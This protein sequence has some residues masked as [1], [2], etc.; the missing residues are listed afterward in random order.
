[1]CWV[2]FL[3]ALQ[4]FAVEYGVYTLFTRPGALPYGMVLVW[5][6]YWIWIPMIFPLVVFVPLLFPEGR[7]RSPRWRPVAW[8]A[9]IIM[10]IVTISHAFVPGPIGEE[11][12][13]VPNPYG[14]LG[15]RA[16][17]F[18]VFEVGAVALFAIGLAA[19]AALLVRL[20]R[21][22]GAERQQLKWLTY[23]VALATVAALTASDPTY[24]AL[25]AITGW[26][27]IP[28]AVGIAILRYRLYDIDV[29]V[30]R[31]L[32]YG[33]LTITLAL[34]YLGG[35]VLLQSLF[36]VVAGQGS[37]LAIVVSTL[38][39]AAL[40]NPLRRRIQKFID[41]R[42]Y[43]RKYDAEQVLA[44]FSATVRDEA[45]LD[46]M[47]EELLRVVEETMQPTRVS[48]WLREVSASSPTTQLEES[49]SR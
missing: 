15:V 16:A 8:L 30:N 4:G 32:V 43:R 21:S 33:S 10:V 3:A 20:R 19:A 38:A 28:I 41:R 29:L 1:F 26:L 44:S 14:I 47:T 42:F 17:L 45:D 48:L 5:L 36:R 18:T 12:G 7:L 2:G 11:F 46:K 31:T 37:E 40:F 34:V 49:S 39:I 35:V 24:G 22:T 25:I 9:A 27:L 6:Q 13:S 23:A